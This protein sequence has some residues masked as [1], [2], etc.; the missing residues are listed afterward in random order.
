[1]SYGTIH[2]GKGISMQWYI[3]F[4]TPYGT[5]SAATII[6]NEQDKDQFLI[7]MKEGG[8]IITK[9]VQDA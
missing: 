1:M 7:D 3:E 8:A 9:V 6:G 2:N 5:E 4:I